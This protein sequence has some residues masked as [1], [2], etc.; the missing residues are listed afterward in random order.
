MAANNPSRLRLIRN[1]M[2]AE[3]NTNVAAMDEDGNE[4]TQPQ[5]NA[6]A[7]WRSDWSNEDLSDLKCTVRGITR[8]ASEES[9][10]GNNNLYG[11]EICLHKTIQPTDDDEIEL[12]VDLA[13][14]IARYFEVRYQLPGFE[15]MVVESELTVCDP[16]MLDSGRFFSRLQLV[17]HEWVAR[18]EQR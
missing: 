4:I 1:A 6:E 11:V 2:A 8:Q 7:K 9:Y 12:L 16:A 5:F 14:R 13:E 17:V 10:G 18:G 3:L 15:A